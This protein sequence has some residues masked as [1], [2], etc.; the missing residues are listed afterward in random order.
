MPERRSSGA[1]ATI[2]AGYI[3][4]RRQELVGLSQT[5]RDF[6]EETIQEVG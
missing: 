6:A 3:R 1:A 5:R 2:V 4:L